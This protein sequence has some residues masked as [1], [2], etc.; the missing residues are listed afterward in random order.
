M[1]LK[2]AWRGLSIVRQGRFIAHLYKLLFVP[3][4][5][6]CPPGTRFRILPDS[7]KIASS[8]DTYV[9]G[10][11]AQTQAQRMSKHRPRPSQGTGPD[12]AQAQAQAQAQARAMFSDV[13]CCV[14]TYTQFLSTFTHVRYC[15]IYISPSSIVLEAS[16]P[17]GHTHVL[18]IFFA[19]SVCVLS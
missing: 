1:S 9:S 7:T 16:S 5:L 12:P 19:R 14:C 13:H 8:S 18:R 15:K 3:L 17:L 2:A 4:C 10:P 6:T 11:E